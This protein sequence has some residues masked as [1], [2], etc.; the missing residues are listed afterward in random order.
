[1]TKPHYR[2]RQDGWIWH[3][4]DTR[5]AIQPSYAHYDCILRSGEERIGAFI[6]SWNRI[7]APHDI[8][9]WRFHDL[10]IPVSAPRSPARA[11]VVPLADRGFLSAN[12]APH[13]SDL[14]VGE[15]A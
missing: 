15:A 9:M 5:P 6:L 3:T 8:M 14:F 4:E 10:P 13:W 1:V 11:D 12:L 2:I 7:G